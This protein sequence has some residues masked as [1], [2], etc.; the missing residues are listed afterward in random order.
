MGGNVH[1]PPGLWPSQ[2]VITSHTSQLSG[3][4]LTLAFK[5]FTSYNFITCVLKVTESKGCIVVDPQ[6][7]K[8]LLIWRINRIAAVTSPDKTKH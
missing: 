7:N 8:N 5:N 4:R 3:I 2:K 6:S 1:I